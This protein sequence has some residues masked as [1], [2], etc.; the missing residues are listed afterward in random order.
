MIRLFILAKGAVVQA[1]LSAMLSREP[2]IQMVGCSTEVAGLT[3]SPQPPD[4]I[5]MESALLSEADWEQ[6]AL[7]GDVAIA[8]LLDAD[9][10]LSIGQLLE[11]GIRGVLP[12]EV[13]AE[14][15][16]ATVSAI[17]AGLIV[18]HPDILNPLPNPIPSPDHFPN[19]PPN[20]AMADA[21][22]TSRELEVLQLLATGLGNR[23][24]AAQL[25]ISEHTVKFHISSIFSKLNVNS[26]TEAVTS[27]MRQGLILI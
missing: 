22:L 5:L 19:N 6:M 26:R 7:S 17:A 4:V 24:I 14:E 23:A 18:L 13:A 3:V 15:L 25:C 10:S 1:G 9:S 16:I 20:R 2:I 27:A 21:P 11:L 8:V 12:Q